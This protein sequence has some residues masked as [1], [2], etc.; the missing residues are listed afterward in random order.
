MN[1]TGSTM[2]MAWRNL[3]RNPRRTALALAAIGGVLRE[4]STAG[5]QREIEQ[6]RQKQRRDD[7][8]EAAGG[9]HLNRHAPADCGMHALRDGAIS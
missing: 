1:G 9:T 8:E 6:E 5:A 3:W 2:R 7:A 4:S